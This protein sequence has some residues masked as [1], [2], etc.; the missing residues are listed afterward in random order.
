MRRARRPHRAT[1]GRLALPLCLLFAAGVAAAQAYKWTDENGKAHFSDTPP[2]DRKADKI[3]IKPLVPENP[4]AAAKSRDW[5]AQLEESGTR[6]LE[7][8]QQKAAEEDNAK[9][10]EY[11]CRMA[12][13]DLGVLN[14]QRP[15]VTGYGKDGQKQ[16]LDDKDRPAALKAAQERAEKY[17]R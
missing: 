13:N 2:F 16:Y 9:A 4:A 11:N 7:A 15:V 10:A 14:R 8:Q 1:A 5:K 3:V 12:R 6:R 17:C